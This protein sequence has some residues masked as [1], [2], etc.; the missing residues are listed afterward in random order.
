MQKFL[1]NDQSDFSLFR[2]EFVLVELFLHRYYFFL[3]KKMTIKTLLKNR[4][5]GFTLVEMMISMAIFSMIMT[6]IMSSVHSMTIARIKNM[7]RLALTDQLYLFSEQLFTTIKNGGTIDYE[8][9]WNRKT[10]NTDV[11]N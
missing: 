1:K 6:L 4:K 7:N 5:S 9:Y 8:E 2:Q 10:F 11:K 3:H